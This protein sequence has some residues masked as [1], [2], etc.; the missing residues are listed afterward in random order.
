MARLFGETGIHMSDESKALSQDYVCPKCRGR[1]ADVREV[2]LVKSGLLDLL[3]S[4]DNRYVEVTCTLCGFT[5]FYNRALYLAA[6]AHR[7]Q[8]NEAPLPKQANG[9]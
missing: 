8:P 5:E 1:A 4:K 6:R 2:A 7:G 3:P 9:G